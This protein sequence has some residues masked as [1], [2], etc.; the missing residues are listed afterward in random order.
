MTI[1]ANGFCS[2]KKNALW[3]LDD[4]GRL[5][6]SGEGGTE[7]YGHIPSY[8]E[9]SDKITSLVVMSGITALSD[10]LYGLCNLKRLEIADTVTAIY[11]EFKECHELEEIIVSD[12]LVYITS[13][14]LEDTKWYRY[15]P[16]GMVYLGKML[17]KYKGE[18]NGDV[19]KIKD[20]TRGIARRA[21][22]SCNGLKKIEIPESVISV[23]QSNNTFPKSCECM[24]VDAGWTLESSG[25]LYL[26]GVSDSIPDYISHDNQPWKNFRNNI[27]AIVNSISSS[28]T[29]IGTYAFAECKELEKTNLSNISVISKGAFRNCIRLREVAGLDKVK[30]IEKGAFSGCKNLESISVPHLIKGLSGE[31]LVSYNET[32]DITFQPEYELDNLRKQGCIVGSYGTDFIWSIDLDGTMLFKGEGDIPSND[33]FISYANDFDDKKVRELVKTLIL[34]D[35]ITSIGS[36]VFRNFSKLKRA[37]LPDGLKSINTYAFYECYNLIDVNIPQSVE[38]ILDGA[39]K[40]CGFESITIPSSVKKLGHGAFSLCYK[41]KD[42]NLPDNI[43]LASSVFDGTALE[44]FGNED[45][46]YLADWALGFKHSHDTSKNTV[47]R[48]RKG[49][50]RI[51]EC[52]FGS[53]DYPLHD[54]IIGI[55]LDN[56]ITYLGAYAFSGCRNLADVKA[57]CTFTKISFPCFN[58]T[59]WMEKQPEGVPVYLANA[60]LGIPKRMCNKDLLPEVM[61]IEAVHN[62]REIKLIA[63][64]AFS[65]NDKTKKFIIP[66]TIRIIGSKAFMGCI[67]AESPELPENLER[68]DDKAFLG[69]NFTKVTIPSSV[70]V[71]GDHAFGYMVNKDEKKYW[72]DARFVRMEDFVICGQKETEAER[73]ALKNG[74]RFE[75]IP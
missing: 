1:I 61:E 13:D 7:V 16:D 45:I 56:D 74:I 34:D 51:A 65:F 52:A 29:N 63:D 40:R 12:N 35:S 48:F 33:K 10:D 28:I 5:T 17:Y 47:V 30:Y 60:V 21:F 58:S 19:L 57:E 4:T 59:A 55:V 15:Q 26:S 46:Y 44:E 42:V 2:D 62:D 14:A 53:Y 22:S 41:L 38:F 67:A 6:I 9:Y 31:K 68:I 32:H 8:N 25:T 66:Q 27:K 39:F 37:V 11:G 20:G 18:F 43:E 23:A 54:E 73:Y 72:T 50:K 71:I 70:T 36:E 49:T 64:S 75:P 24:A 3:E 69:C